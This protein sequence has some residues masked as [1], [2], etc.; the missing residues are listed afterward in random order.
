MTLLDRHIAL[1]FLANFALLFGLLFLF[2]VSIDAILQLDSFT[3]AVRETG[4]DGGRF[5]TTLGYAILDFYGPRVFQLY[6]YLAGLVAVGAAGFTL[7]QMAR[8]RE[9]VAIM[10]AGTSLLRVG[11][12]ILAAATGLNLLQLVNQEVMLPRLAPLLVR[13]HGDIL[14]GGVSSFEV[15][16]SRDG[17]GQLIRM[18]RLDPGSGEVAGFLAIE[19]DE[20]GR[21]TARIEA[22]R[23][24]WDASIG[25]YRL[26]GGA[27]NGRDID[28]GIGLAVATPVESVATDL[29]PSALTI[30]RYEQFAQM[31]SLR[32][33]RAMR[34]TGG[35]DA[36]L[37][38]R[39][40]Y[41]RVG[42]IAVNLLVLAASLP[43]FLRRE[44]ANHLRQS[45]LCAAFAVP[46]TLGSFVAMAV[47]LPGLAPAVGVLL[48]AATLLPIAMW[49]LSG[50]KT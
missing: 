12:V 13:S 24:M 37:L 34:E 29:S 45:I 17:S 7:A 38:A 42:G 10:A 6:A 21:Q 26:D 35:V 47:E 1:R 36:D 41:L 46:A 8:D 19:R 28:G 22:E 3:K 15:P 14:Q 5:W 33:L 43:F 49:R 30:R 39:L 31:L 50:V 11:L 32:Q 20:A 16:L 27:R 40:T 44:P 23:A 18:R 2:V 9:L 25:A 4:A 48:P